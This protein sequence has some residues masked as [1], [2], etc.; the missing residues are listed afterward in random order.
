MALWRLVRRWRVLAGPGVSPFLQHLV[1]ARM[2]CQSFKNLIVH[3][4]GRSTQKRSHPTETL[5]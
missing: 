2:I 1:C 4:K 3:R 5:R